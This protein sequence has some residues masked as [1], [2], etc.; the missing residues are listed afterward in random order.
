METCDCND[1]KVWKNSN[2][3]TLCLHCARLDP[4][5][6]Q[7]LCS[8]VRCK[9]TSAGTVCVACGFTFPLLSAHKAFQT[10]K[11]TLDSFDP[12][13][14]KLFMEQCQINM[15]NTVWVEK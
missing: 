13:Q 2:G 14:L 7:P 10:Q 6:S 4:T 1:R 15:D 12:K 9:V 8:H 5:V 11:L 3:A